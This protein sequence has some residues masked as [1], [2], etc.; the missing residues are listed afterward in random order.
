MRNSK[1][2]GKRN[3]FEPGYNQ[4]FLQEGKREVTVGPKGGPSGRRGQG[5]Q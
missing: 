3:K 1:A 2:K 4:S 5:A